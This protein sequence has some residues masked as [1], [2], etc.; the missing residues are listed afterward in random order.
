VIVNVAETE[1]VSAAAAATA[2]ADKFGKIDILVANAG[3]AG[4]NLKTWD[5]P[6]DAWKQIIDV[7]LIGV[8]LY[9]QCVIDR[10][11]GGQSKRFCLQRRAARSFRS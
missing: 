7:N 10:R 9:C 3:V 6:I 5:Y 8:F 4:P 1:S 11:Q 2:T